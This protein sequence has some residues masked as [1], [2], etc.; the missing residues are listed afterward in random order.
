MSKATILL[1]SQPPVDRNQ[2]PVCVVECVP[3]P[4]LCCGPNPLQAGRQ[5]EY[6]EYAGP[7]EAGRPIR[8][9]GYNT[10]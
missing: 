1:T 2:L 6:L 5:V 9:G 7:G 4:R 8:I 3:Q 10:T